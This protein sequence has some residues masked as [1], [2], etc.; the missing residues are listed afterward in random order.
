M[1]E[2]LKKLGTALVNMVVIATCLSSC[3]KSFD[4]YSYKDRKDY[5]VDSLFFREPCYLSDVIPK[6]V[7]A[8]LNKAF[9]VKGS[10]GSSEVMIISSDEVAADPAAYS[11]AIDEGV[12]L[13]VFNPD[14]NLL[15]EV[16]AS[17]IPG[18]KD[19]DFSGLDFLGVNRYGESCFVAKSPDF[20]YEG[21][22]P[23]IKW[24]EEVFPMSDAD[25]NILDFK[26]VSSSVQFELKDIEIT[27]V[28]LSSVDR[29]SGKGAITANLN[30]CP[31]HGFGDSAGD[32]YDYYIVQSQVSIESNSMYSGNFIKKHGGVKARICGFYLKSLEYD[33][34]LT[35]AGGLDVGEF[36]TVPIPTTVAGSTTY[37]DSFNFNVSGCLSGAP[38]GSMAGAGLSF[39]KSVQNT[40][41]DVSLYNNHHDNVVSY[42]LSMGNL[43]HY[44]A[45]I[46][47]SDPPQSSVSTLDIN[48]S[49]VWRV[50]T[51]D[52]HDGNY[53][54]TFNARNMVYGASY[55]YSSSADYH[56]LDFSLPDATCYMSL[57]APG[58]VA[59]GNVSIMCSSGVLDYISLVSQQTG[60]EYKKTDDYEV[61]DFIVP[62]GKYE[63]RFSIGDIEY[64][65]D[66]IIEVPRCGNVV[67]NTE[68]GF[69]EQ[70]KKSL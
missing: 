4:D 36:C 29:L 43:P 70:N 18:I 26:L 45:K 7:A 31:V 10:A 52:G 67:L 1:S 15:K 61:Y 57:P 20:R 64:V 23:L 38:E 62:E 8:V 6:D 21:I 46:A 60:K 68:Y 44:L 55:M 41:P 58:R 66:K 16:L 35:D 53:K 40:I 34:T 69:Q 28:A 22:I 11:D 3:T 19:W 39:S 17:R 12:I 51:Y 25:K 63:V 2:F 5:K 48:S 33:F 56:N 27:H 14:G 42:Q 37:T 54:V 59:T 49:W 47:I 9:P 30:V 32:G 50:K 24:L 65:Y 13:I